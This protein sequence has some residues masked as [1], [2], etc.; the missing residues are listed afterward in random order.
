MHSFFS[1]CRELDGIINTMFV[2]C[3]LSC[4]HTLLF[5]FEELRLRFF[6]ESDAFATG[7]LGHPGEE[8]C[9]V[10]APRD[11]PAVF[12]PGPTQTFSWNATRGM[13]VKVLGQHLWTFACSHAAFPE[14]FRKTSGLQR[15]FSTKAGNLRK[16]PWTLT[17]QYVMSR[18][19]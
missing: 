5:T 3:I 6:R 7:F 18:F 19:F 12:S 8:W 15:C 10:R 9:L 2:S 17:N 13:A 11:F 16:Q 14:K 4:S 1:S